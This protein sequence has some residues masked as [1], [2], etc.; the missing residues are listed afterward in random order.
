MS[1]KTV[2]KGQSEV[3]ACFLLFWCVTD[4]ED[5]LKFRVHILNLLV[6]LARNVVA[7]SLC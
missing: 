4:I 1:I 5:E 7:V 6:G 3:V 2:L